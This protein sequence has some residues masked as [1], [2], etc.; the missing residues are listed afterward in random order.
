MK[1]FVVI[2]VK[3]LVDDK[4]KLSRNKKRSIYQTQ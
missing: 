3:E 2:V 4:M 1:N